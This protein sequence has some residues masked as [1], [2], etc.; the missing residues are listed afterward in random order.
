M[1]I[2][3]CLIHA[4]QEA[5]APARAAFEQAWPE[6]QLVNLLDDSLSVDRAASDTLTA[7]LSAR[8]AALARHAIDTGATGVLFTCSAFGEAIEAARA[9]TS[10][11][12]LKPN[13][14]M[15]EEALETGSRIAMLATFRPSIASMESEFTDLMKAR[16]ERATLESTWVPDAMNALRSGDVATH[17]RLLAEAAAQLKDYDA[18]MLAQFGMARAKTSVSAVVNYPVLT[19]PGSAV[20]KLKSLISSRGGTR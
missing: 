9:N 4:I 10:I 12:M 15:F 6:A 7:S 2:R 16:S 13:E 1:P 8:I 19:S 11:P 14:A 18:L 3:I 5:I 17:D 20:V